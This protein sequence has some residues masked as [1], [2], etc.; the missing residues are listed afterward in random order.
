M[1]GIKRKTA[2]FWDEITKKILEAKKS[3]NKQERKLKSVRL[4]CEWKIDKWTAAEKL[5][6]RDSLII[7]KWAS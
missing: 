2:Y 1:T 5:R 7:T 4:V 6:I 3:P